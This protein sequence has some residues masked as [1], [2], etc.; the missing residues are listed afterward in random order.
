MTVNIQSDVFPSFNAFS[1]LA[2]TLVLSDMSLS[3]ALTRVFPSSQSKWPSCGLPS[4]YTTSKGSCVVLNC[5][6]EQPP[7]NFQQLRIL[8]PWLDTRPRSA[9]KFIQPHRLFHAS[10]IDICES[11]LT[12]SSLRQNSKNLSIKQKTWTAATRSRPSLDL[13]LP[14]L[15]TASTTSKNAPLTSNARSFVTNAKQDIHYIVLFLAS[16]LPGCP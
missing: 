9:L 13:S 1:A 6:L 3:M 2:Q 4:T 14:S 11:P 7:V 15:A 8:S 10:S 12:S 5:K 16:H